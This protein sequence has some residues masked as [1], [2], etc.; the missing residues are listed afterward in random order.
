MAMGFCPSIRGRNSTLATAKSVG[1]IG[2][3]GDG[4][5]IDLGRADID[6][7]MAGK[8]N[9]GGRQPPEIGRRLRRDEIG[10]HAVGMTTRTSM[11]R[12]Q[13]ARPRGEGRRGQGRQHRQSGLPGS[14]MASGAASEPPR[15]R[16][17]PRPGPAETRDRGGTLVLVARP[18]TRG[19]RKCPGAQ[20]LSLISTQVQPIQRPWSRITNIQYISARR[21]ANAVP[22]VEWALG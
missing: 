16:P 22:R 1:R 13:G 2:A 3:G 7:M 9:A 21:S 4:R 19:R 5:A 20:W 14:L 12:R 15:P 18:S 11:P 8:E 17:S 10:A 6:R